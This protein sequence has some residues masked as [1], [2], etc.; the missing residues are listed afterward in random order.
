[1]LESLVLSKQ[2]GMRLIIVSQSQV[3]LTV[4]GALQFADF[5]RQNIKNADMQQKQAY[6]VAITAPVQ[7]K[8]E[9]QACE[10]QNGLKWKSCDE[11]QMK[12]LQY[13]NTISQCNCFIC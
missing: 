10:Y 4:S 11:R 7:W 5:C 9:G 3:F 1:M 13:C 8:K 6:S 2:L 12:Q